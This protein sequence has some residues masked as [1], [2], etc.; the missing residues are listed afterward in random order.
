MFALRLRRSAFGL[1]AMRKVKKSHGGQK[2]GV[3]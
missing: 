2:E 1:C 3:V